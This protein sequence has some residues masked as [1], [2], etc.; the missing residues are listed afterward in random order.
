MNI[1][2]K[3]NIDLVRRGVKPVIDAVQNDTGSRTVE[4]SLLENGVPWEIPA[5]TIFLVKY[6]R[7]DGSGGTYD[8]LPDGNKAYST[9]GNTVS[10]VLVSPILSKSGLIDVQIQMDI[11]NT[12]LSTF[13]FLI[14]AEK[15]VS[16]S[17]SGDGSGSVPDG[18]YTNIQTLV[19]QEVKNAIEDAQESGKFDGQQGATF[20]PSVSP[21]GTISW[22]NDRG[23]PN[24]TPVNIKG[25][26]GDAG[27]SITVSNV[28]VSYVDGGSNVVRF[29][30][31]N[32]V[33]ILNGNK[34]NPGEPGYTPQKGTDYWTAADI[35]EI[36]SY[37]DDAIL[38]GEW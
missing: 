3:I 10:V 7:Q 25:V 27:T 31:G 14:N 16:G 1:T 17:S 30:D 8:T 21:E 33:T 5:K 26:K 22:S 2:H 4:I 6:K 9:N 19:Q 15:E 11:D 34:G 38:G 35:A 23:L 18:D 20:T 13:A 37:V 28:T 36:K 24:P 29:S 12:V 32:I